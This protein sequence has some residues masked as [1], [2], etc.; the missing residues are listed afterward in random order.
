MRIN[1]I[2]TRFALLTQACADMHGPGVARF[3]KTAVVT[4]AL[5]WPHTKQT[6]HPQLLPASNAHAVYIAAPRQ[7]QK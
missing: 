4:K 1:K 6:P 3:P 2:N 5:I 7:Q